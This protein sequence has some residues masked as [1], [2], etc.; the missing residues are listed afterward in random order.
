MRG[1]LG[2]ATS[3]DGKLQQREIAQPVVMK[4]NQ[5]TLAEMIGVIQSRVFFFI[6]KFR[7]RGFID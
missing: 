6:N 5:A 4:I 2:R 1:A 7:K 3:P